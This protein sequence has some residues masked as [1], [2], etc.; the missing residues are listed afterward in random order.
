MFAIL[1]AIVSLPAA[2]IGAPNNAD[3]LRPKVKKEKTVPEPATMLLVG[4]AAVGLAGV[5]KLL[6]S[7]RQ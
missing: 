5:R 6:R 7:K 1:A 3:R 2:A 4:A